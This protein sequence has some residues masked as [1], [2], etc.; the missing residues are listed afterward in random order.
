MANKEA[1][2]KVEAAKG[3]LLMGGS[4]DL[5]PVGVR[6]YENCRLGGF[7]QWNIL[8]KTLGGLS[9][10]CGKGGGFGCVSSRMGRG[11]E[12]NIYS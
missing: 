4:I 5:S 10:G 6:E 11:W 2:V 3:V 12:R 8:S 9:V 7:Q 1:A